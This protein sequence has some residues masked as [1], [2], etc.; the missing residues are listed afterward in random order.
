MNLHVTIVSWKGYCF[1]VTS[2]SSWIKRNLLLRLRPILELKVTERVVEQQQN[3]FSFWEQRTWAADLR[4]LPAWGIKTE[5]ANFELIGEELLTTLCEKWHLH[6]ILP[7]YSMSRRILP[8]VTEK[9][10]PLR[11]K[12]SAHYKILFFRQKITTQ[13]WMTNKQSELTTV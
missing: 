7:I 6:F 2:D 1:F 13:Y 8:V 4:I 9:F 5:F 12:T 3:V 10:P 11:T